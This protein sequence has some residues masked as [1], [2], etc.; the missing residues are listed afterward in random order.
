M[1][2]PMLHGVALTHT[3]HKALPRCACTILGSKAYTL[4]K[5]QS[6]VTFCWMTAGVPSPLALLLSPTDIWMCDTCSACM[7]EG[8]SVGSF[9][10]RRNYGV[11][12]AVKTEIPTTPLR[13]AFT[14]AYHMEGYKPKRPGKTRF[15]PP[16][17]ETRTSTFRG[18]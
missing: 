18:K 14:Y 16:S 10:V 7:L 2:K 8:R 11:I 6:L 9:R 4:T 13:C 3:K 1:L 12:R 17:C 15:H 5:G